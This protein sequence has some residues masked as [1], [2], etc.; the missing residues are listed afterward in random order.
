MNNRPVVLLV[1]NDSDVNPVNSWMLKLKQHTVL[2]AN[3]LSEAR[4]Y[5]SEDDPDVILLDVML[6]D[7]DGFDFCEEIRG[8]TDAYIIFLTAESEPESIL[9]G[10]RI[11]G[12][13]YILKPFHL[14]EVI[15]RVECCLRRRK[16]ILNSHFQDSATLTLNVHEFKGI[17]DNEDLRLTHKEF[18]V[19]ALLAKNKNKIISADFIYRHAWHQPMVEDTR[20]VQVVIS[21]LRKKIENTD[22]YIDVKRG[23]GYILAV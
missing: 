14:D 23:E 18:E 2:I 11:G 4:K 3:N 9:R 13:G 12:D 16:I 7:G 1:E 17:L 10:L 22:F 5:L 20:A 6:A 8:Q 19:L 15:A 21:K